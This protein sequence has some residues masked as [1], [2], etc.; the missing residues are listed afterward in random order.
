MHYNWALFSNGYL[1][2]F[3]LFHSHAKLRPFYLVLVI[4]LVSLFNILLS[5]SFIVKKKEKKTTKQNKTKKHNKN[6]CGTPPHHHGAT[7]RETKLAMTLFTVVVVSLHAA[8]NCFAF[9]ILSHQ[10]LSQPFRLEH[11]FDC[12]IILPFYLVP[13]LL[14]IQF[15]K[16]LEYRSIKEL[17]FPF[18]D[19]DLR[20]MLIRF[21][22]LT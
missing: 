4:F 16:H 1:G 13:T 10:T 5:Y 7:S 20:C 8:I 6:G 21:P 2:C 19:V 11:G 22:F 15:F 9:F 14:S 3:S 18:C 12:I 17:C